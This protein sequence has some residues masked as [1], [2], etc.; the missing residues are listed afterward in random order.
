MMFC[1]PLSCSCY[2][3][4]DSESCGGPLCDRMVMSMQGTV[5]TATSAYSHWGASS[6]MTGT[7]CTAVSGPIDLNNPGDD[8]EPPGRLESTKKQPAAAGV[9]K[10]GPV[11]TAA[12]LQYSGHGHD[13]YGYDSNTRSVYRG[14]ATII[15]GV[16][17]GMAGQHKEKW[18]EGVFEVSM[19]EARAPCRVD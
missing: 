18:D 7:L 5:Y 6:T 14:T 4:A 15:M 17:N 12:E 2:L 10:A 13:N 3:G 16:I 11:A 19:L 1:L 8:T 9:P